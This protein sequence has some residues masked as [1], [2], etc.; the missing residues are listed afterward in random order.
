MSEN[1]SEDVVFSGKIGE[2]IHTSQPDGRVFERYRRPPGVRL[3][4]VTPDKKV[5]MTRERRQE[6]GGIDLRLP[7]GKVRDSLEEYHE[8]L[9][10]GQDITAAAA[11]AGIKEGSEE[12]GVTASNLEL[13]AK[14]GAGATVEWDLYYFMTNDY[15]ENADGQNLEHGEEIETV[16]LS[17]PEIRLAIANGEMKEWRSVGILLGIVLPQL[18][19]A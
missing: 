6:T 19:A 11:E 2:V 1:L 15:Q 10:S 9:A 17:A 16:E 4:I 18:E 3:V 12:V 14:A 5:I 13:I 7:G 8:L